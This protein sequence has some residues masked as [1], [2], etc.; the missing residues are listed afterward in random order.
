[1]HIVFLVLQKKLQSIN[2]AIDSEFEVSMDISYSKC[3][4][5]AQYNCVVQTNFSSNSL[6]KDVGEDQENVQLS[7][8]NKC[9]INCSTT[10]IMSQM[11]IPPMLSKQVGMV[12]Y[13]I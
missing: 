10:W 13:R 7:F 6:D 2:V 8:L 1:M 12:D 5:D 3:E 11:M 4:N 9:L